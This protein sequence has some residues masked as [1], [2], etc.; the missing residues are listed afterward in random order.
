MLRLDDAAVTGANT[1][2]DKFQRII[3]AGVIVL[4]LIPRLVR[5]QYGL[6]YVDYWDEAQVASASQRMLSEPSFLP[7]SLTT[8]ICPSPSQFCSGSPFF[9]FSSL[10]ENHLRPM[11]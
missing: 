7:H 10:V 5:V 11:I 3:F 8:V 4:A 2:M 9:S 1:R 6:P